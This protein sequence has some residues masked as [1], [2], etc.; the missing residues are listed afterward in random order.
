ME[1]FFLWVV[2]PSSIWVLFDAKAIGVRK[3]QLKGLRNMGPWGWF[4]LTLLF[5]LIG[6]STY[7]AS[8]GEYKLINSKPKEA[9]P[10]LSP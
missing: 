8:R 5:W 3:G 10:D 1:D 4:F 9:K 2:I 7:M 6:F